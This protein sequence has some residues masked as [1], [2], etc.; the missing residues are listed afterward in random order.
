MPTERERTVTVDGPL[1]AMPGPAMPR[2]AVPGPAPDAVGV[3]R[4]SA[5]MRFT[6]IASGLVPGVSETV[7]RAPDAEAIVDLATGTR[8]TYRQ[9]WDAAARVAGGLAAAGV[10]PGQRVAVRLPNGAAWCTAMLGALLAGAVPVPVNPRLT[11]PELAFIL[12]DAR[13][14]HLVDRP[15]ALPDGPPLVRPADDPEATAA[16]FYTSRTT[17]RPMG[18]MLWHRALLSAAEQCRRF[19]RLEPTETTR[20]VIAAPLFHVLV[21]G[22]QWLPVLLSGGTVV[23]T[24]R[25]ETGPWLRAIR[26]ERVDVLH[27]VPAMYWQALRHPDF[28]DLDV[29]RVRLVVYGAAPI[30]ASQVAELLAAFPAARIAPGYGMTEAPA[31]AG[32]DH[33]EVLTHADSVGVAATATEL[34]LDGPD[35]VAGIGQLLVR[36]PQVMSG[37]WRRPEAS[38][39]ALEGGWLHTGDVARVDGHGRVH[40]LDRIRDMI[41]RGGENVYSIEVERVL[42][43]FPGVGEVAVIGVPDDTLGQRVAAAVVARPGAVLDAAT[44]LAFARDQLA[45][46]KIPQFVAIVAGPLPRNAVGMVDKARLRTATDWGPRH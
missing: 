35:A 5:G 13:P 1:R 4:T 37:Y 25:F 18:V 15:A 20:S 44:L 23:I 11:R 39:A 19:L 31:V 3:L 36:G 30:P 27:G 28:T 14:A 24:T 22:L 9:L 41:K 8:L 45:E 32:L 42:A 26:D 16:L 21:F 17:G 29:S 43:G 38:V 34:R 2:L 6:G 12:D 33:A 40:L 7:L 10:R 46:F